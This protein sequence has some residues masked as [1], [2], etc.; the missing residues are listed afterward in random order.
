M[1]G[2]EGVNRGGLLVLVTGAEYVLVEIAV[3]YDCGTERVLPSIDR[4]RRRP[5]RSQPED[6]IGRRRLTD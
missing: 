4:R 5:P 6:S 2:R 3:A 1:D